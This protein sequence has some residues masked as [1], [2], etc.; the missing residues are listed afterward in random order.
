MISIDYERHLAT[1]ERAVDSLELDGKLARKVTVT[2]RLAA[3]PPDVWQAITTAD[4][5]ARWF[6]PISGDLKLGGR[7][8][9]ENHAGGEI[10]ACAPPRHLSMTWEF[11]GDVSWVD[12]RL[13]AV[14]DDGASMLTLAHTMRP[15]PHYDQFGPGATGVGWESALLGVAT[16]LPNPT[17]QLPG[18]ETI[19]ASPQWR[20]FVEAC[21]EGWANAAIASG[22]SEPSARAAS[23]CAEVS[24][25]APVARRCCHRARPQTW[26]KYG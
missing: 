3:P 1:V 25:V 13:A 20:P 4:R 11:A 16:H 17:E 14:D 23:T 8:Q 19:A 5:I 9:L 6:L 12:V 15:S 26:M 2:Q 10:T 7:F 18:I 21:S 24:R 22:E